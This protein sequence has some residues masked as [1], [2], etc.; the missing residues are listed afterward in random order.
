MPT[1]PTPPHRA[2]RPPQRPYGPPC[3]ALPGTIT[4]LANA[5]AKE[6]ML[7][8]REQHSSSPLTP[9]QGREQA[10]LPLSAL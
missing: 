7:E 1:R 9:P 4:A 6:D 2:E 3:P 5:L 8:V 10:P